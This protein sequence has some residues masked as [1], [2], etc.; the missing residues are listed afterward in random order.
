MKS[1][2][3][4]RD[5]VER[6]GVKA[7]AA[8]LNLS[9]AL[10]Y[11]WCQ[12]PPKEDPAGSGARNP[13]DRIQAII[14]STKDEHVVN[15]ICHLAD[16]FFTPNPVVKPSDAEGQLLTNTHRVVVDFGDLLAAISR[17]IEDDGEISVSEAEHIRQAWETLK[18]QAESF[19]VACEKGC[20]R[21]EV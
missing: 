17:G 12:E 10:I 19:V 14:E 7:M 2:E 15:W 21:R 20:Y 11:K 4:L 9:T 3:V 13:L 16:G 5:A 1:W 18:S 6:V 8:K